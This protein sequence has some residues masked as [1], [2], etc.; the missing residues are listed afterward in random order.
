MEVFQVIHIQIGKISKL[1]WSIVAVALSVT[2]DDLISFY[3]PE[4]SNSIIAPTDSNP[5]VIHEDIL[6]WF[7]FRDSNLLSTMKGGKNN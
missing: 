5:H 1:S 6:N 7:S 3:R 4:L 2:Y